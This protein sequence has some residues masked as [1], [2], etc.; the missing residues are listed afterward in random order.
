MKTANHRPSSP[1]FQKDLPAFILFT[2]R[3]N[4]FCI[5]AHGS[6]N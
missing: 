2:K 6:L 3:M 4:Y 5:T 1:A